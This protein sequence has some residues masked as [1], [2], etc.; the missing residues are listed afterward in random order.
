MKTRKKVIALAIS[1]FL[2]LCAFGE[3][4][5]VS[6]EEIALGNFHITGGQQGTDYDLEGTSLVIK[7][8]TPLII[9]N[10]NPDAVNTTNIRIQ[11]GITANITLAGVNI[12]NTTSNDSPINMMGQGTTCH[13]T[14]AD[15][16]VNTLNATKLY[17]AAL[18][19]GEGSTL[20]IDGSGTLNAYGGRG[21][22]G[23][24]SGFS[25][26]AGHLFFNGG[27]INAHAWRYD[28]VGVT[29]PADT[30]PTGFGPSNWDRSDHIY[31]GGAGIGAGVY[32]GAS[33]ITI[34]GGTIHAYGSAHGAGI[35]ASYANGSGGK[36]QQGSSTNTRTLVCGDITING[37]YITSKGYSHGAAFGGS[38]GTTANGCTIR[39][40][41]GTLLP[42]S[43]HTNPDFNA[44]GTGKVY[45]TGGS[46][47]TKGGN[48]FMNGSTAGVAFDKDGKNVFMVTINLSAEGIKN[49]SVSDWN[50][51]IGGETYDYGAPS[52]FDDGKLYLWVP[53]ATKGK[54]ISVSCK[55][56]GKPLEPL[57]IEDTKNDGSAVLKRYVDF[58]LPKEFINNLTKPYDGISFDTYDFEKE[59]NAI[60]A[61]DKS[62]NIKTLNKND[63]VSVILQRYD[64]IDGKPIE[65]EHESSG[66]TMPSDAGIYRIQIISKQYANTDGF[67]DSYWGHRARGW[68]V[69]KKV[70][71]E[72]ESTYAIKQNASDAAVNPG[73]ITN[74]K[75]TAV[76]RPAKGTEPTCKTPDGKVQFYINGVKVGAPVNLTSAAAGET[77][78]TDGNAITITKDFDFDT[79]RYPSV[80]ELSSGE[81]IV[82]AKYVKGTNYEDS[83]VTADLVGWPEGDTT[84][85][86]PTMDDIVSKFPFINPPTPT[87]A[88]T[89]DDDLEENEKVE[90]NKL[91]LKDAEVIEQEGKDPETWPLHGY[92][93]DEVKERINREATGNADYFVN[94]INN[95]Y[96]FTSKAGYPLMKDGKPLRATTD[97]IQVLDKDGN[98]IDL[99]DKPVNLSKPGEYKVKVTV[100]DTNGNT[101]T[102]EIDYSLYYDPI[103]DVDID[104][105]GDDIPDMNIDTDGDGKPDINIDTDGDWKPEVNVDT[106]GDG[107]PD[108]NVDTD[109]DGKPDLNVDTD[110]DG[111]PD[112]NVDTDDDGKP[113]LNVDTD[114]DGKPDLNVD[115]DDDGKPDVNVDKD[116]DGKP[117]LNVDTDGDGKPDLNIDKDGDGKPDVN[118]DKD[119]DGKPDINIDTDD[120]GKPDVNVDTD[121]DGIPDVSIDID[122][123]GKPDINIDTD[124]DGKPDVNIVDKDGDGKPDDLDDK[125]PDG[126]DNIKPDINVDTDGDGKSDVNVDTDDDGKPDV[127]IDIDG[128]GKPDI[129][130]DKDGDG[131]PDVNIVDKDGDGKPDDLDDKWPNGFDNIKPDINVDTDDDGK[132]DLNVDT[133]GD[134]KP[135][136]NV[137]TDD[138]GKPNLN[139]DTD[140]DGKADLNIDTDGDGKPNLNVDIDGDGKPD[141][142]IDI[143]GDGIADINLDKDGDGKV[144]IDIQGDDVQKV[145]ALKKVRTSDDSSVLELISM[146]FAS[147]F[148]AISAF[149]CRRKESD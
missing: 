53:E 102:I 41:G 46:V 108:L 121:D 60:D 107:K 49:D 20:T 21:G 124:E 106:D 17:A 87:I 123:D 113:D 66:Y 8:D 148:I 14:L 30:V 76:V 43:L 84:E 32:G 82:E 7:T 126:F 91:V 92:F 98:E 73:K 59:G 3:M 61:A 33:T 26:T 31:S 100:S 131:K 132:P 52:Y 40:T 36:V 143:D 110:D 72:I 118:V 95:R 86:P 55:H 103:K 2:L 111:K 97:D 128:D 116:G 147:L 125:W 42:T 24:G 74:V 70:P 68:A 63:N 56:D 139:I 64:K 142:N 50:V 6:A 69:I 37:G 141:L 19:C 18:H 89:N 94:L 35:G 10:I 149:S 130:I 145:T 71:S 58:E 5:S 96:T 48:K 144:D 90:G 62:G 138:D 117:D 133:D 65:E 27:I 38:C 67:K 54:T 134:G 105:D 122:G 75:A 129:N 112:V 80:P 9:K 135:D 57:Y 99:L 83:E 127:S 12:Q 88:D 45:I 15:G 51:T 136:L 13:I 81:F 25:E 44:N 114:G 34:N 104:L 109:G 79:D 120:D 101:T 137:D 29:A 140:G 77:I 146:A 115:T 16:T 28:T 39:V 22:A 11:N 78:T 4:F 47:N 119:G 23:I 85:T 1:V 93:D